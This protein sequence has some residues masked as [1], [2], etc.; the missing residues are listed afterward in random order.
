MRDGFVNVDIGD[1]C[2]PDVFHDLEETPWP[3]DDSVVDENLY[4]LCARASGRDD[5][6]LFRCFARIFPGTPR[7]E[8][9]DDRRA[10]SSV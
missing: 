6:N 5:G 8:T 9:G 1:H 4:E 7:R 3:W 2:A 10:A